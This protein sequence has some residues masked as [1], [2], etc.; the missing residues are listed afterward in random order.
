MSSEASGALV[1]E[2]DLVDWLRIHS[3]TRIDAGL[4]R[5]EE[6]R[7]T[8]RDRDDVDGVQMLLRTLS[9]MAT[10]TK[11]LVHDELDQL[12]SDPNPLE[13]ARRGVV[14]SALVQLE[15]IFGK[16]F[17][18][19]VS[20]PDRDFVALIRPYIRLARAVTG[21]S[22]AELI[23]ESGEGFG[24]SVWGNV[25]EDVEDGVDLVAPG[26]EQTVQALPP[27]ALITYPARTGDQTLIHSLV[28]H[29]VAHLAL[30]KTAGQIKGI[31][32]AGD[33]SESMA[34]S[35]FE[36]MEKPRHADP[37]AVKRLRDWLD[38]LLSD[39]LAV[40]IVGPAFFFALVEYL[41]PTHDASAD[42]SSYGPDD[43][44]AVDSHP[45]PAWRLSRLIPE[46]RRYFSGSRR[47]RIKQARDVFD[48]YRLMI[49]SMSI[50]AGSEAEAE[51]EFL[52]GILKELEPSFD[53]MVGDGRYPRGRFHRDLPLIWTKLDQE[54]A[55]AERVARRRGSGWRYSEDSEPRSSDDT[56]EEPPATDWSAPIDWRS[57]LNG[58]YLHHL[59]RV[60]EAEP[61]D[62]PR[63]R[64]QRDRG[65][66]NGLI[67]GSIEL[68]ELHRQMIRMRDELDDLNDPS[69]SSG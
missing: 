52:E 46:V 31:Q 40:R 61:G 48:L 41:L 29:E 63:E 23:F 67:R 62:T 69:R 51:H 11:R 20:P 39:V 47:A 60:H 33:E 43:A 27:L 17:E 36:Q 24:Y 30:R 66:V 35:A 15:Q 37:E 1:G 2:I 28:G 10:Q 49:P 6:M 16:A 26:L 38:E 64:R 65:F 7:E 34:D 59:H 22:G 4:R 18:A 25:F 3:S 53:G 14:R 58:G 68:S 8:T 32:E 9:L 55:P 12:R 5:I 13:S 45:P 56:D 42:W 21:N 54:I 57:I 50:P 44:D 19:L